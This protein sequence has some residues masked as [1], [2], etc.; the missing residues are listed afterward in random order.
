VTVDEGW[1][2]LAQVRAAA[3]RVISGQSESAGAPGRTDDPPR[4]SQRSAVAVS[5]WTRGRLRGSVVSAPG[6]AL[7]TARQA[8]IWA[9]R[10]ARFERLSPAEVKGTI[11][12]IGFLHSPAVPL[13]RH[14]IAAGDAY[15]D[16]AIFVSEGTRSGVYLPEI[17][18][19]R[20]D[21]KLRSLL[22][23]L[24][25]EKAGLHALG[26]GTS[27]EVCEVTEFVESA[28]RSRA[29]PLDG[30]VARADGGGEES[31]RD[32]ARAAGMAACAWLAA[33]QREDGAL[34]L[35][36]RPSTG[37]AEGDDP[38]RMAL[39]AQGLAAFGVASRLGSA[40]D[41]ARRVT[42]WL[43]RTL[44]A[45]SLEPTHELLTA[46]YRGKVALLLGDETGF[47]TAVGRVLE[48]R[49]SPGALVLAH[50]ASLL[51]KASPRHASAARQVELLERE[52]HDRFTRATGEGVA[53]SLAEWAEVAAAFP[54][55]TRVSRDVTTWLRAAQLPSGAFPDTTASDFAY[56]RGTGKVFEVLA[57]H[58]ADSARAIERSFAWLRAMQ[59][60]P[61]SMFFVPEEH[62]AR[63][64][65]GLRHDAYNADAW[66]DAAGHLL[67]GLSRLE[68]EERA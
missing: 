66:I 5:M 51:R 45:R 58:R 34:P 15:P 41:A 50:V 13:S 48:R 42:E 65:G 47:E 28:E 37:K 2:A 67:I 38:V 17:F 16:K 22:E 18:N 29:V 10:D 62:R 3:E 7:R 43:D 26:P 68:S 33:L 57:L 14:E 32:R 36:I 64:A 54:A 21:R 6:P 19:I 11:F 12:Q 1:A 56:S 52:L 63:I 24:A 31:F 4:L 9:C 61:D 30:P 40:V 8:A 25:R 44:P 59:Y 53:M 60:R 35:F 39:A 55:D 49:T 20:P 46:C 27:V 23:A